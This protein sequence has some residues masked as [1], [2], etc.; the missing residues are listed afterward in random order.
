MPGFNKW[1]DTF[2]EEKQIPFAQWEIEFRGE[3][4]II[5][6]DVVIEAIKG[7]PAREQDGIKAMLVRIDFANADV[8]GYFKH[9]AQALIRMRS[10]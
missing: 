10:Q 7:A 5:N 4:H 1:F 9:L 8:L 3:T 2:L 6:S